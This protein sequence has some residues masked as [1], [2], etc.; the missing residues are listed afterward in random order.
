MYAFAAAWNGALCPRQEMGQE[1]VST[2]QM[3]K[4][5]A[6]NKEPAAK[7][8]GKTLSRDPGPSLLTIGMCCFSYEEINVCF[9]AGQRNY[10][11][12]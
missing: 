10:P 11:L 8:L 2:E 9:H 12:Q 5:A 6:V 7:P 4:P 3:N 1:S